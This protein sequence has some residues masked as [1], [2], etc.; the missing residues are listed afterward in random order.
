MTIAT[1]R[2]ASLRS[3]NGARTREARLRSTRNDPHPTHPCRRL[4]LRRPDIEYLEL[5]CL[6][7]LI[8]TDLAR[9]PEIAGLLRSCGC[10]GAL[11]LAPKVQNATIIEGYAARFRDYTGRRLD[12]LS[13]G[14]YPANLSD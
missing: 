11:E 5:D 4:R 12:G 13:G 6:G 1:P 9:A 8:A 14:Y 2:P 10:G 3:G 7:T